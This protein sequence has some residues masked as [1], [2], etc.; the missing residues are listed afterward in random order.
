MSCMANFSGFS[1]MGM[2][3]LRPASTEIGII[4]HSGGYQGWSTG[5]KKEMISE[6]Q[7]LRQ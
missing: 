6:G 7:N 5:Q 2:Y 1:T 4:S 3:F